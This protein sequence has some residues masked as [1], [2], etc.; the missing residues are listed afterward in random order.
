MDDL[1]G[2]LE[3]HEISG[4]SHRHR[5]GDLDLVFFNWVFRVEPEL[6][7]DRVYIRSFEPC[8]VR[9]LAEDSPVHM[10]VV[11]TLVGDPQRQ[12]EPEM[13]IPASCSIRTGTTSGPSRNAV[14]GT[15][16][17]FCYERAHPPDMMVT[18]GGA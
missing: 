4:F 16:R 8:A 6:P 14:S 13:R 7:L 10:P 1:F 18:L 12:Q 9:K 2:G 3:L 11:P 15:L 17:R 5:T